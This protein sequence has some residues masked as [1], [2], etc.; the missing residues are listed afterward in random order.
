MGKKLYIKFNADNIK[1]SSTEIRPVIPANAKNGTIHAKKPQDTILLGSYTVTPEKSKPVRLN[2]IEF[3]AANEEYVDFRNDH[4]GITG[5][6]LSL[7]MWL[8]IPS[9][10]ASSKNA[11]LSYFHDADKTNRVGIHTGDTPTE[12]VLSL[13]NTFVSIVITNDVWFHLCWTMEEVDTKTGFTDWNIYINGKK[14]TMITMKEMIFLDTSIVNNRFLLGY[15]LSN[16]N[17]LKYFNGKVAEIVLY[18]TVIDPILEIYSDDPTVKYLMNATFG[19]EGFE[20]G[21][22]VGGVGGGGKYDYD[23]NRYNDDDGVVNGVDVSNRV[24]GQEMGVGL[25]VG[26]GGAMM[27]GDTRYPKV[28]PAPA[29]A[30]PLQ[31]GVLHPMSQRTNYENLGLGIFF[32]IVSVVIYKYF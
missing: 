26:L 16:K 15:D 3:N 19:A 8:Y 32:I 5:S 20:S 25:G 1:N 9:E 23:L 2:S 12:L 31:T 27:D 30:A 4:I 29:P 17:G 14:D 7:C 28:A 22:G 6:K 11:V 10:S 21:V 24:F 13:N 18:D